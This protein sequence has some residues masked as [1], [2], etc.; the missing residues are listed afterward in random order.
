M[1]ALVFLVFL[2]ARAGQKRSLKILAELSRD[3]AG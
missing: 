3:F 2:F 1:P